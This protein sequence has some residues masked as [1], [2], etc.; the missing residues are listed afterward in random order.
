MKA[1]KVA[2]LG[3]TIL[4]MALAARMWKSE[5][6]WSWHEQPLISVCLEADGG[7]ETI[8]CWQ[9][10]EE[11]YYVFLPSP[12]V[13]ENARLQSRPGAT[14][15]LDGELLSRNEVRQNLVY[16]FPYT[17]EATE[18]GREI[19]GTVTFLYSEKIPSLFLDTASGSM[20]YIHQEKDNQEPGTMRLY[21]ADGTLDYQGSLEQINGR[22]NVTWTDLEKKPYNLSLTMAADLLGMGQGE[23]WVLLANGFDAT[24]LRNKIV[25]D[26]SQKVCKTFTPQSQW[27]NL[28]LN[29]EYAGLYLLC[30]RIEIHPDKVDIPQ[31]GSFLLSTDFGFRLEEWEKSFFYTSCGVAMRIRHSGMDQWQMEDIWNAAERAIMAPDGVDPVT[32]QSWETLIDVD[33]WARKLLIE[34]VFGNLDGGFVSQYFYLDGADTQR[35]IVAGP[36]WDYD[37]TMGNPANSA[38]SCPEQLQTL[39]RFFFSAKDT[40]WFYHLYQK[41]EFAELVCRLYAE[42]FRPLLTILLDTEVEE[43]GAFVR[44]AANMNEIRWRGTMTRTFDQGVEELLSF[45]EQR[46][47]FLDSL[48]I[49]HETYFLVEALG[50]NASV[51]F[52]VKTGETLQMLKKEETESRKWYHMDTDIPFDV[53]EPVW[54]NGVI[55]LKTIS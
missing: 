21:Q 24:N 37:I 10:G 1:G 14:V 7:E 48:W 12:D 15:Y 42:E 25:L 44:S 4:L 34:E 16:N 40:S 46:L 20:E 45:M 9:A 38:I 50:M 54:E 35:R 18:N 29:G 51:C 2:V 47:T 41:P 32:G 36:V 8:G 30:Q 5:L 49:D 22:G 3:F 33:S 28:Y 31:K 17:I 19:S 26:F 6:L 27:V 23:N 52:A 53:T 13:L 39:R 11:E 43:Y 55:V